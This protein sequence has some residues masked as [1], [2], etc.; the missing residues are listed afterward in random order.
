MRYNVVPSLGQTFATQV[1]I[2]LYTAYN[3][4]AT[5]A[6]LP[7]GRLS[8]RWEAAGAD[9]RSLSLPVAR[10]PDELH[11]AAGLDCSVLPLS[12]QNHENCASDDAA[13][14]LA[15]CT[16]SSAVFI[17][18]ILPSVPKANGNAQSLPGDVLLRSGSHAVPAVHDT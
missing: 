16:C 8:D 14:S 6:S 7:V 15:I 1:A 4:A 10:N 9:S 12:C 11:L 3:F 17:P 2:G 18:L 13:L 5:I